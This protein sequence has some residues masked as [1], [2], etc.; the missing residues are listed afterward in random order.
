[1]HV[2]VHSGISI[3]AY[4]SCLSLVYLMG[5]FL[6]AHMEVRHS[7]LYYGLLLLKYSAILY[8]YTRTLDVQ[9]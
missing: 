8:I 4:Q 6:I 9:Y 5:S 7:F 3:R 2:M 1:M